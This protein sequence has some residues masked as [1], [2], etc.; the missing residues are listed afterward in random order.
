MNKKT[1]GII[2][3][4]LALGLIVYWVID[5]THIYT[6]EQ[7]QVETVDSLFGQTSTEWKD[8]FHPGLVPWIASA[9]GLLL[10][11]GGWLMWGGRSPKDNGT[12][13]RR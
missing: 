7:V 10:L 5:G 12:V 3:I 6:V 11:L 8:E 1:S 2:L 9:S 13:V 4:L